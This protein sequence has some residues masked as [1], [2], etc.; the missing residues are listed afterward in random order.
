APTEQ[1]RVPVFTATGLAAGAHVLRID[2]TGTQNPAATGALVTVDAF[3]VT[4]PATL[5]AV[6]RL[7]ETDP[8]LTYAPANA[9][10]ASS[11]YKFASGEFT[12]SSTTVGATATLTFTGTAVRW[13]GQGRPP[14]FT[15]TTGLA[16]VTL[17]GV[18]VQVDT[19]SVFQEA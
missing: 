5:P 7:Q 1:L 6:V 3:V 18:V 8:A 2:V 13:I 12:T 10:V 19:R 9:W 14:N 4:L 16:R 15:P 11:R 17:D